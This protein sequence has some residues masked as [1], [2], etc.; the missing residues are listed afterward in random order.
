MGSWH[1]LESR[2][3]MRGFVVFT[4]SESKFEV[5]VED[6]ARESRPRR[7]ISMVLLVLSLRAS[8]LEMA[9]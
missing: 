7:R 9:W 1:S 4:T 3:N 6:K 5:V 8:Y 2:P